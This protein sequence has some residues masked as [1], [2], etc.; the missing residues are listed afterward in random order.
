ME[1]Q[2]ELGWVCVFDFGVCWST[3]VG[4]GGLGLELDV[5]LGWGHWKGLS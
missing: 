1:V 2:R 4:E 5:L 3:A